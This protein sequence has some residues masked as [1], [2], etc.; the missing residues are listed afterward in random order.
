ME[1]IKL[2]AHSRK[3]KAFFL[4]LFLITATVIATATQAKAQEQEIQQLL[5]DV[6]KLS[7]FKSI[8]SDMKKGYTVLSQGYGTVKNIAQGN[9][10][11]HEVFLDGLYAVNP[12]VKKYRRVADIMED[13][14]SILSEYKKAWK[15]A[16][17]SGSFSLQELNYLS[18]VYSNIT[19]QALHN[20][21]DLLTVITASQLRMSDDERLHEIDRI[22]ADTSDKL[23]FLRNF[24][25]QTDMMRLQRA[26]EINDTK[27]LQNLY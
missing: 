25:R 4:C 26:K 6:E 21:N 23:T 12:N 5:L 16:N 3:L 9:F 17:A 24:N 1:S 19:G 13:E 18:N 8:L 7:Q 15:R 14:S 10:N 20:L 22:Y 11:L 2:K 27:T